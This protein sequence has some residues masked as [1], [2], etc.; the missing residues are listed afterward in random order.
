MGGFQVIQLGDI[1]QLKTIGDVEIYKPES[2][3]VIDKVVAHSDI[4]EE[5]LEGDINMAELEKD[6]DSKNREQLQQMDG[7]A[8]DLPQSTLENS[9]ELDEILKKAK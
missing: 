5:E 4:I 7:V 6:I 9:T 8:V 2:D 3:N 1:N